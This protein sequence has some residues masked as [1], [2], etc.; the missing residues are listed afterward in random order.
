MTV[1]QLRHLTTKTRSSAT[2]SSQE[3]ITAC[4]RHAQRIREWQ[5]AHPDLVKVPD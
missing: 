3:H 2:P 4:R 5:L 1:A